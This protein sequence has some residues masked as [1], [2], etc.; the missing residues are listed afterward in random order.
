MAVLWRM[1]LLALITGLSLG[2]TCAGDGAHRSSSTLV[3]EIGVRWT[4]GDPVGL[5]A[6][7]L[8]GVIQ[9]AFGRVTALVETVTQGVRS[10]AEAFSL[11]LQA[12]L[13]A[14]SPGSAQ[15][16]ME[17]D[18][19]PV[20]RLG[21]LVLGVMVVTGCVTIAARRYWYS[22]FWQPECLEL[23]LRIQQLE[24]SSP[25]EE[26]EAATDLQR[27]TAFCDAVP[28]PPA[29]KAAL[30]D[31]EYVKMLV[32]LGYHKD[33]QRALGAIEHHAVPA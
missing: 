4:Q 6:G 24:A 21:F 17:R 31:I 18:S 7:S 12:R 26:A 33:A 14:A 2:Q 8:S 16:T 22:R 25:Q 23:S 20:D 32:K 5:E 13:G 10:R 1:P 28:Q 15:R 11:A 29:P 9:S 3:S 30:P 19:V 27:R